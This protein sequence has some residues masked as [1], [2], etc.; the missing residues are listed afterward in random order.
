MQ[1]KQLM[2]NWAVEFE[3]PGGDCGLT[4]CSGKWKILLTDEELEEYRNITTGPLAELIKEGV[5]FEKKVMRACGDKCSLLDE[6]G[7]CR[8]V[9][10][11]GADQ[12][13]GTCKLFPRRP[14]IDRECEEIVFEIVCPLIAKNLLDTRPVEYYQVDNESESV[15]EFSNWE[16]ERW[17]NLQY[18]RECIIE[19]LKYQPGR[20][21]AG[22]S[23]IMNSIY[24]NVQDMVNRDNLTTAGI[25]ELLDRYMGVDKV[26]LLFDSCEKIID[27]SDAKINYLRLLINDMYNE[28]LFQD[29]LVT[30]VNRYPDILESINIWLNDAK[31]FAE[32]MMEF[33]EY[34]K[35][36]YPM[37]SEKFFQYSL[38]ENWTETNSKKFGKRYLARLLEHC[39]IIINA[40]GKWRESR[41]VDARTFSVIIAAIDRKV[42]HS[43]W[44]RIEEIC[45]FINKRYAEENFIANV[46]Q[47]LIV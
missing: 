40:M 25:E 22:K 34:M 20:Y 16:R 38:F 7:Y 21:I 2:M 27:I 3:C 24:Q 36:N 26:N 12:I 8:M 35:V 19:I 41:E 33:V 31:L 6:N 29:M 30:A 45:G 44:D 32:D 37:F 14:L 10:A 42:D 11:G 17:N 43:G 4:C 28:G 9:L 46:M 39:M 5:D 15:T 23:F 1:A 18:I 13:S 47:L